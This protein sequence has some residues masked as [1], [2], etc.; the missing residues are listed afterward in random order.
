M[1]NSR[2]FRFA[3]T[4]VI[5]NPENYEYLIEYNMREIMQL[6]EESMRYRIA[7][8]NAAAASNI[9]NSQ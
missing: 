3:L 4:T 1:K 5:N 6:Q 9:S 2:P 7:Q 8:S